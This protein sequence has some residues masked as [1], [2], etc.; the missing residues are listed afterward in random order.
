ME[1][2]QGG[3]DLRADQP[4]DQGGRGRARRARGLRPH[5]RD[6]V[7]DRR[8][9]HHLHR[10]H[11]PRQ[12]DAAAR[13]DRVDQSVR[14]AAAAAVRGVQPRLGQS[15]RW[16]GSTEGGPDVDWDRLA[17]VVHRGVRFLDD[18]I[19]VN[20]YPLPEIDE[21]ARGNRKI[22]LGVMGWA[23]MLIKL[24]PR[25]RQRRRRGPRR[26]GHGLHR[27]RG[28]G[29]VPQAGRGARLVPELR[30]FGLRHARWR[31]DPQRDGHHD[32]ADRHALDHRELL[33]G[34]RA[35][36]RGLATCARSWTTTVWSRSTRCSR[37]SR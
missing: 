22:G 11:Q 31:A 5:H 1:A 25:L 33:L 36:V 12:P 23:D 24:G 35:A 27:R 14:R 2:V 4:A 10:P 20:E 18:V 19:E 9:R 6:G 32:R 13:R 29:G 15:V 28:E 8:P 26:E 16:C 17:D 34:R 3:H 21:L 30:G 7:G 37:R